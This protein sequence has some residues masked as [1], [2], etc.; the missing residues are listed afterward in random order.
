MEKK[1]YKDVTCREYV[2]NIQ[3]VSPKRKSIKPW[4]IWQRGTVIK[5]NSFSDTFFHIKK[6]NQKRAQESA[7]NALLSIWSL[8]MILSVYKTECLLVERI[9]ALPS[10]HLKKNVCLT[11]TSTPRVETEQ[12]QSEI[13]SNS[14]LPF[15]LKSTTSK[16]R[17]VSPLYTTD[18]R[19][20][21]IFGK[22][23][24]PASWPYQKLLWKTFSFLR[25]RRFYQI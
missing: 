25:V 12:A 20:T 23:T 14:D 10:A 9:S 17:G 3:I 15:V 13:Q 21:Y 8:K 11:H 4:M 18:W 1:K 5:H 6:Q 16:K 7:T 2:C 19:Q 22:Q 24:S